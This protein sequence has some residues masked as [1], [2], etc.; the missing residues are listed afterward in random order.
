M[1]AEGTTC[2]IEK[3]VSCLIHFY[4]SKLKNLFGLSNCL[5]PTTPVLG[6]KNEMSI[7]EDFHPDWTILFRS[8]P[9]D[10]VLNTIP[11][12]QLIEMIRLWYLYKNKIMENLGCSDFHLQ[13][14][15]W[16]N[17]KVRLKSKKF[18]IPYLAN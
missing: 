8:D 9:P 5:T 15:I 7:L 10:C 12:C 14:P 6:K 4:F 17:K 18:I 3:D 1:Y 16:W 13:D 11:N 2:T